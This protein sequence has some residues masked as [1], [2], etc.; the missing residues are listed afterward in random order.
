MA[1]ATVMMVMSIASA[2]TAAYGAISSA[3]A[4]RASYKSQ[5]QA[6]NYNATANQQNANAAE[7]AASANELA[8]R[9][10]NDQRMGEIRA[11]I[12]SGAGGFSGTAGELA[13]QDA[14]NMELDALNTRYRG[15]LQA[16]GMLAQSNL[17]Q[18]QGEVAGMNA[19]SAMRA[20]YIGA[21]SS[22]LGTMSNYYSA[23]YYTNNWGS[24]TGG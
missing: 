24:G 18:Y 21:A 8:M 14:S 4:Q 10:Q 7:A 6:E 16:H 15:T 11:A 17:D 1:A 5:Q 2:A 12:A 13:D 19:S 22:A 23:R 3:Q 20:G 9:R